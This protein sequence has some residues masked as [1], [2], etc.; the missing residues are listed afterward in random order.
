MKRGAYLAA[1]KS[2]PRVVKEY[3]NTKYPE[4]ALVLMVTAYDKL[5]PDPAQWRCQEVLKR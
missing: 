2:C 5:G 4:E 3:S 1:A